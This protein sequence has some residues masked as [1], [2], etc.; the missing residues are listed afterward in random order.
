[1]RYLGGRHRP[2]SVEFEPEG[3]D[4]ATLSTEAE[5]THLLSELPEQ[6]IALRPGRRPEVHLAVAVAAHGDDQRVA[7]AATADQAKQGV[8]GD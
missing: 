7:L 6:G 8:Q 2:P 1:M 4:P 3:R 5:S